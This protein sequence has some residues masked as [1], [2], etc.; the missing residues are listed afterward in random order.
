FLSSSSP[1]QQ[2]LFWSNHF[3]TIK[4]LQRAVPAT[5]SLDEVIY[6]A[7]KDSVTIGKDSIYGAAV[8]IL[9]CLFVISIFTQGFGL[10]KSAPVVCPVC[11]TTCPTANTAQAAQPTQPTQAAPASG[12]TLQ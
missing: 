4:Y 7:E 6:L 10:V 8:V 2:I 1:P 11:N 3:K 9:A 5:Y 12:G